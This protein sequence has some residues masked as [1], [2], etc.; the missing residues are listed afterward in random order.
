MISD[1]AVGSLMFSIHIFLNLLL[2]LLPLQERV[3]ELEAANKKL[4]EV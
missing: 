1:F 3:D 4:M 2:V